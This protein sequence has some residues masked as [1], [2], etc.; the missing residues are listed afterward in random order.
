MG[1]REV[2]PW[3]GE[4]KPLGKSHLGGNPSPEMTYLPT[5]GFYAAIPDLGGRVCVFVCA[6]RLYPP[7]LAWVRGVCVCAFGSWLSPRQS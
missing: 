7:I 1:A 2:G 5:F 4:Q 6:L 3:V